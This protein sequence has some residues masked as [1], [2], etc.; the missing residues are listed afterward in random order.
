M[1]H[2]A[3]IRSL[4]WGTR[5]MVCEPIQVRRSGTDVMIALPVG[6]RLVVDGRARGALLCHVLHETIAVVIEGEA[7][8]ALEVGR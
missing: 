2:A 4:R 1:T 5:V 3:A 6:A 8:D 7:L